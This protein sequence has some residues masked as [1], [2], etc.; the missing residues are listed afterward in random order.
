M[1]FPVVETTATSLETS[2][3]TNHTVSLPSGIVSGN[4]LIVNFAVDGNP[5]VSW[6]AGWTEIFEVAKSSLNAL[7]VAYRK[8]DG[9][10]SSTITVTT[11]ASKTS[12]HT[13][14][15]ISGAI[16]PTTQAPEISTG[17]TGAS[18][19]PD[20]DNLT[21]TGG[22]KDYLWLAVH[23]H[24]KDA[25]T[26]AFPTNYTNGVSTQGG[27]STG[28]AIGSAERNLNAASENPATFTIGAALDWVAATIA[29]HPAGTFE[30][31]GF[32]WRND[33][34]SESA[35]SWRQSQD[36]NDAIAKETTIRLRVLL[37]ATLDPSGEQFQLE[38]KET[39]DPAG[40]YRKVPL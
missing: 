31:E 9:T 29:I 13:S 12:S 18:T 40:D 15:R 6:P 38:Y 2:G 1:A 20:P 33:D 17:A 24:N 21:P 3:V 11:G 14:Y 10:E 34:G 4:L 26:T 19:N 23:G 30:Q 7:A 32:R 22:A 5:G 37:D 35:A 16:D 28:S 39:G 36:V 27:G 8:A 25:N